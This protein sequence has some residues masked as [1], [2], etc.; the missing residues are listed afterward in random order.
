MITGSGLRAHL[1][2]NGAIVP[3][4]ER[5]Q[6]RATLRLDGLG[7]REAQAHIKEYFLAP[8]LFMWMRPQTFWEQL[9]APKTPLLTKEAQRA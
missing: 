9:D 6:R 7:K 2:A 4:E 8:H 1:L 3:R 5:L